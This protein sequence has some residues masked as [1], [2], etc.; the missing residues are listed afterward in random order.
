MIK[1]D[2]QKHTDPI[3]YLAT[4]T[5][6]TAVADAIREKGG[7]SAALEFPSGFVSAIGDIS[8]GAS[9]EPLTV[10]QN[11]TYTAAQGSAYNPVTVNVPSPVEII[12]TVDEHGGIVRTINTG[13]NVVFVDYDGSIV[14]TKTTAQ[15]NAMSSDSDLPANPSH[16]GLTA[17]GWN[18]TVA[19]LKAQLLAM[20]TQKIYV[21]QM[22]I[23]ESGATEIDIELVDDLALSPYLCLTVNGSVTI[24]WGDNSA[25]DTVT[26]TSTSTRKY[27]QHVYQTTGNYTIS[28]TA[29]S[30]TFRFYAAAS[31][32]ILTDKNSSSQ[33]PS[34]KYSSSVKRI[35]LGGNVY[36][37]STFR[38]HYSIESITIPSSITSI[39][40]S[41]F[42]NCSS[43]TGI[44]IPSGVTSIGS[45]AFYNC[46]SLTSVTIPSSVTSFGN[47]AFYYCSSLT[48]IT[49]PSG[50][51]SIGSS[52]F[53]HCHSL[54]GI[55]IPS[56][57]TS[58][59]EGAFSSCPL[60]SFTIPSG[61]TSIGSNAFYNCTALKS[62]TIPSSVTSIGSSAFYQCYSLKSITIPSSVKSIGSSAFNYCYSLT[63]ITIPSGVTS[64][65]EGTFGYCYSLESVTIPSSV[66]SIGSSAFYQCYSITSVTIPSSVTSIAASAFSSCYSL[67][68]ITIPSDVTS[69]GNYALGYCYSMLA[70]HFERTTPPTLGT[71][72]FGGISSGCI[73]YVPYSA[74]HSVLAAYQSETN[75]SDYASYMQEEPA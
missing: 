47:Y 5:E 57:V 11:G 32:P 22:Y 34:K 67:T 66:T 8:T 4:D 65:G 56:G 59:G 73:I 2:L 53:S 18:W 74:D 70:Y 45:N 9:A 14:T 35:R 13:D 41:A 17:Q 55:T 25:T 31:Y 26:G 58:I 42:Y 48:G 71:T 68:S 15:I 44:T 75:W 37:G 20:P 50:V 1:L 63:G 12:D 62:V 60:T 28:I 38:D 61:V 27:T 24:D 10:T 49:I 29:N 52:T 72:A 40:G 30:G 36:S 39:E 69:I 54:T 19:Q 7:T 6:L 33:N 3:N 21:G 51:T 43:L 16:T 64:I 46:Y 23:T